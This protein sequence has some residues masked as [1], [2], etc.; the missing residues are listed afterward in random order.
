MIVD[1]LVFVDALFVYDD[2]G[3]SRLAFEFLK[4]LDEKGHDILEPEVFGIELIS[5]LVRR[6][7]REVSKK[8]Y[9]EIMQRVIIVDDIEY[10]TL[11]EIALTTGCRA[12]D[13]YYIAVAYEVSDVLVSSDKVMV[14]N[15]RKHGVEAYYLPTEF[16]KVMKKL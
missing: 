16:E 14:D 13:A 3:R 7:P 10:D 6:R 2:E 15:A 4:A 5:Q 12:I 9:D 8:I 11:F 1:V